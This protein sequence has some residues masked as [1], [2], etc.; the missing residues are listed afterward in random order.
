MSAVQMDL[1]CQRFPFHTGHSG[2]AGNQGSAKPEIAMDHSPDSSSDNTRLRNI[3][4]EAIYSSHLKIPSHKCWRRAWLWDDAL[5][6]RYSF[7]HFL[8]APCLHYALTELIGRFLS[9]VLGGCL[10]VA[11]HRATVLVRL[12]PMDPQS[13]MKQL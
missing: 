6:L 2:R 11:Q 10:L 5:F 13:M 4:W 12:R 3:A 8:H 9:L 7:C 1:S